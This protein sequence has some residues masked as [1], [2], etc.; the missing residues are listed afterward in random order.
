MN[1]PEVRKISKS[2]FLSNDSARL[3]SDTFPSETHSI[4]TYLDAFFPYASDIF[5]T[6]SSFIFLRKGESPQVSIVTGR[7]WTRKELLSFLEE[8]GLKEE[9]LLKYTGPACEVSRWIKSQS[10]P[11]T[12]N[13]AMVSLQGDIWG[14]IKGNLRR[15]IRKGSDL[16]RSFSMEPYTKETW[17]ADLESLKKFI[18]M[19]DRLIRDVIVLPT[20]FEGI[21]IPKHFFRTRLETTFGEMIGVTSCWKKTWTSDYHWSFHRYRAT[22]INLTSLYHWHAICEAQ[23]HGVESYN[24]GFD[25]RNV[26]GLFQYKN[27]WNPEF[28][29]TF[30][31]KTSFSSLDVS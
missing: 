19:N 10:K 27:Q 26:P 6:T 2:D 29:S 30:A 20:L 16:V 14:R 8:N 24:L 9:F 7:E 3:I 18:V 12:L 15:Q 21:E 1:L 25:M 31:V 5:K 22:D 23:K 11:I 17:N 4:Q 13:F 28:R